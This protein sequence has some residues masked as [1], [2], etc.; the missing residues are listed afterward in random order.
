LLADDERGRLRDLILFDPIE[1][2]IRV[3]DELF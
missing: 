1:L 2:V 3:C